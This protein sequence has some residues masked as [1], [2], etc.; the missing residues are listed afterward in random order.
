MTYQA[1]A[2]KMPVVL[3]RFNDRAALDAWFNANF[4][5]TNQRTYSASYF[6]G[7]PDVETYLLEIGRQVTRAGKDAWVSKYLFD[8]L[9]KAPPIKEQAWLMNESLFERAMMIMS[10]EEAK[11]DS[12]FKFLMT[13]YDMYL[14][15]GASC[16]DAETLE[17]YRTACLDFRN[18]MDMTGPDDLIGMLVG[19]VATRVE[20]P[21]GLIN[22]FRDMLAR[23]KKQVEG[24]LG[25]Q[26]ERSDSKPLLTGVKAFLRSKGKVAP[27]VPLSKRNKLDMH[28]KVPDGS[29]CR[30]STE[31][32]A[33]LFTTAIM[34][35]RS[36]RDPQIDTLLQEFHAHFTT[37]ATTQETPELEKRHAMLM[38]GYAACWASEAET[39]SALAD[40]A[41]G[42]YQQGSGID[43]VFSCFF[44]LYKLNC[45]SY[46]RFAELNGLL[47]GI[48]QQPQGK[49]KTL[50]VL[51]AMG[52]DLANR[53]VR[54]MSKSTD[55][56][57]PPYI[58]NPS[59]LFDLVT[60]FG[61]F[62]LDDVKCEGLEGYSCSPRYVLNLR[63]DGGEG[64]TL[65]G[66]SW[67]LWFNS[68]PARPAEA[69][70]S[71]SEHL[72]HQFLLNKRSPFQNTH[73][74][75]GNALNVEIVA[76]QG[77]QMAGLENYLRAIQEA[78]QER[79]EEPGRRA[80]GI[81]R[82]LRI[83]LPPP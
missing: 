4:A 1:P 41:S 19:S 11:P 80:P 22:V 30:D 23:M 16:Q 42:F 17:K 82:G 5:D 3:P 62:P 81:G 2:A 24:R 78:Q 61:A 21:P 67:N 74:L 66:V 32:G 10:A 8:G 29:A 55:I 83:P 76:T 25:I 45:R 18:T 70:I 37:L 43:V 14:P 47:V 79:Q 52:T 15:V 77:A 27:P 69:E 53:L 50:K 7:L 39:V 35:L 54:L 65:I 12:A 72:F 6:D 48:S 49:T 36:K 20:V 71:E 46:A 58:L 34:Q 9:R 13:H 51:S 60:A 31:V 56:H 75:E 63:R 57:L 33:Y 40:G 28:G 38:L 26:T 44:W 73:R 59:R 68:F 64:L